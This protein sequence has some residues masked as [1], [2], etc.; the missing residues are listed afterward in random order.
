MFLCKTR[1]ERSSV[2]YDKQF[3]SI[4][5]EKSFLNVTIFWF[6]YSFMTVN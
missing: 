6:L 1:N 3:E 4:Y 2:G 5:E